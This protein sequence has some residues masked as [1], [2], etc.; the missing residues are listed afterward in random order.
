[1]PETMPGLTWLDVTIVVLFAAALYS[2]YRRGAV[3][4]V[5]GIGGLLVGVAAGAAVAPRVAGFAESPA[6]AVAFVLGTVLVAA[7]VGNMLGYLA[8]SWL[9]HATRQT[10]LRRVDALGG[11]ALS[12]A[13]LLL[14]VWFLTLNLAE[15]P[16]PVVA[17]G[18]RDSTIVQTLDATLPP[19]PSLTGEAGRL[20][21]LLGFADLSSGLPALPADPVDPPTGAESVAAAQAAEGSTVEVSA[22]GCFRGYLNQGSGFVVR[23]ELV[24]TNAHVVAGTE[25]Q[26]VSFEGADWGATVVS[27]DPV[28]DVALLHVPHLG[29]APLPLLAGEARRGDVGAVLGYPDGG[30]LT[31]RA[32]A[33]RAVIEPAGDDIYGQGQVRRRTYEVQA[34]IHR[35]NSGGPLVLSSGRVAGMVFA[36]SAT[37]DDVGYAIVSD[38]FR[39]SVAEAAASRRQVDTGSCAV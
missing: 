3:L 4:Q 25:R 36:I 6:G 39:A 17:R 12:A 16:F 30:P 26:S 19:P 28:L 24:I 37:D 31:A 29:L 7:A 11:S 27:F 38:E 32:A 10:P 5:F 1:M 14:A 13:C 15:G 23:H 9:K 20:L 33:V 18:V 35:G 8:G 22:E 34:A 2:G 21:T